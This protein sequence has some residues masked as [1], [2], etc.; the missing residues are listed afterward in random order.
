[1]P[2]FLR[3]SLLPALLGAAL[4]AAAAG[5]Q[6]APVPLVVERLEAA[7]AGEVNLIVR[8]DAAAPLGSGAFV[9]EALDKAGGNAPAFAAVVSATAFAGGGD[10][11][12][13]ALL[14]VPTQ[15]IAVAFTSA[16][17]T[18]NESFGPLVVVRLE[19]ATGLVEDQRFDIRVVPGSVDLRS[20]AD[21]PVPVLV[22]RGRLRLR[23]PV[24]GE[25]D[26]G[27][28]GAEVPPGSL[29]VFG[30]LTGR[31]YPIGS[32]TFEILYDP[33]VT[34]APPAVA[35]DPRYGEV[36]VDAL[37]EPEPGR[38]LV[39][40]HSPG[41]ALNANL[42]GRFLTVAAPTRGDVAVGLLSP[43]SLGPATELFDALGDPYL[44]EAEGADFIDFIPA[45]LVLRG[46]FE[47][48]D[49]FDWTAT[50]G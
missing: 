17:A 8:T 20:P 37:S 36:V 49:F 7:P 26:P 12:A 3:L 16:S 24:A 38:L 23:V 40:F 41:A 9:L 45:G 29:A 48:G 13:T 2:K 27:P 34:T 19:L 43:I 10:A 18:L 50:G 11:T 1:M 4:L 21:E 22:G 46:R 35:F 30:V 32:G 33:S 39:T 6:P 28:T 15:T 31:P 5:A 44:W 25:A 42:H 14:D 47:D